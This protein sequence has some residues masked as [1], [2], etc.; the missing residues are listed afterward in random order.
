MNLFE[1][2]S[3]IVVKVMNLIDESR[4]RAEEVHFEA[5]KRGN[6]PLDLIKL[7]SDEAKERGITLAARPQNSPQLHGGE[8]V[9]DFE[10]K[11]VFFLDAG[12]SFE[13][14]FRIAHEIGHHEFS[15]GAIEA[16]LQGANHTF[17]PNISDDEVDSVIGYGRRQRLSLIHI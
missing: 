7:V 5:L 17:T 1:F 4:I 6:N 12:S 10:E 14:A 16:D 13:K 8:A 3:L 9:F 11:V 2:P 15:N